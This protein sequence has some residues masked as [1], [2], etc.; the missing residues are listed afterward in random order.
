[1][2]SISDAGSSTTNV[3]NYL[4]AEYAANPQLTHV[5]IVGD[6]AHLVGKYLNYGSYY[7]DYSGY[8]DWWFGQLEGN[9]HY[10]ELI[11]GRFSVE[12]VADVTNHVNKVIHYERDINASDTWITTAQGVSHREGTAGHN[13]EDDYQHMDS[14]VFS[15]MPSPTPHSRGEMKAPGPPTPGCGVRQRY[16][17]G[18]TPASPTL[19]RGVRTVLCPVTK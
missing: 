4:A 3:K 19:L 18:R 12:S 7:D 5:I 15:D 13:G 17:G 9:D 6:Y 1:M 8:S 16:L 10:N 2:V 11:I 14:T